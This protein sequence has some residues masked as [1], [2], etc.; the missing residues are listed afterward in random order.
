M[1]VVYAQQSPLAERVLVLVNDRMPREPGT[2]NAGASAFV[3]Q[4]Y[5][6]RRG[7]P[8]GNILHLKTTPDEVIGG[9]EFKAQI[10]APLR[11]F[12][13]ANNGAMRAKI[14]YIV[15]TYGVP[16]QIDRRLSVDSV[17]SVMYLGHEELKPP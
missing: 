7:I 5:A 8:P 16:V 4:H 2:G 14:L 15:P 13:D 10:E 6:S 11:K 1:A 17:L 12:L 9:D 3:G